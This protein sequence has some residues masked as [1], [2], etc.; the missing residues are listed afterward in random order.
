[1]AMILL[2]ILEHDLHRAKRG[3]NNTPVLWIEVPAHENF[4]PAIISSSRGKFLVT[5]K[6]VNGSHIRAGV[7]N[8][9]SER[10]DDILLDLFTAAYE[11]SRDN[12][13][14]NIFKGSK[15]AKIAYDYIGEQSSMP[16]AQPHVCLIPESWSQR[17]VK[18]FLGKKQYDGR[19]YRRFCH[20]A[21]TKVSF[22]VFCSRPDMVGLYTQ[23]MGG[24]AS[25]LLHNVKNGLAFCVPSGGS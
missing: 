18:K 3:T 2:R 5:K 17:Q 12:R 6:L 8:Y 21:L 7:F 14:D 11:L 9:D 13:W 10:M 1:V 22:P 15:A 23:F 24:G 25:I 20:V 16:G 19:K 4:L